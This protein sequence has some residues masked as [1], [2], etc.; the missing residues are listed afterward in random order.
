MN[1][2]RSSSVPG[3]DAPALPQD[4]AEHLLDRRGRGTPR[5][6]P[7]E[8]D[9]PQRLLDLFTA[10]SEALE[11]PFEVV[12]GTPVEQT[13]RSGIAQETDPHAAA[14]AVALL[15]RLAHKGTPHYLRSVTGGRQ[16]EIHRIAMRAWTARHGAVFAVEAVAELFA[17]S[18]VWHRSREHHPT[19][20]RF[21]FSPHSVYSITRHRFHAFTAL[22]ET[23]SLL[24]AM[25]DEDYERARNALAARRTSDAHVLVAAMLMPKQDDWVRD[26]CTVFASHRR[27]THGAN[28]VWA[29]ASTAEHLD[30]IG[31]KA[32]DDEPWLDEPSF[33]RLAHTLGTDALPLLT[34]TLDGDAKPSADNRERIYDLIARL[35]SDDGIAYLTEHTVRPQA[36]AALREAAGRFPVRTL[37]AVAATA[38]TAPPHARARIAG[39]VIE[40]GL[41]HRLPDLDAERR[42]VVEELLASTRRHPVA[43]TLPDAFATPPWAPFGKAA[44]TAVA[45]LAAP[46]VNELRWAPGEREEWRKIVPGSWASYFINDP[47]RWGRMMPNGPDPKHYYFGQYLAW[48]SNEEARAALALW[49][50]G[51]SELENVGTLRAILARFGDEAASRVLELAKKRPSMRSVLLPFVHVEAARVAADLVARPRGDRALGRAW[52]DRHAADAAALLIPDALGKDAK[53]RLS[54]AEALRHLAA[55]HRPVLDEQ[56]AAYGPEAAAAVAAI[57]DADPLDPQRRVSKA[58]AWADPGMLPPLLLRG[59]GAALPADAVRTFIAALALDDPDRL[60]P[61]A[62]LLAAECD[63]VSLTAFSWGLFELWLSVGSPS[64]DGWAMDQLRRFADDR[65]VRGLTALIREWPGQSQNRKAVR[66][67]EILGHIG[68]EAALRSVQSIASNAK[69]KALKKTAAAQIEVI[70]E[71]LELTLDQLADRLVP[72]FG[73][74]SDAPLV[75][76]YGPRAFTVKFDEAL[77]PYVVDAKGK[78]RASAPKPAVSDD[79]DLAQPAYERFALLRKEIKSAATEQVKRLEDAMVQCRSWTVAEF[80]R[81]LVEHPVTWQLTGRLVWEYSTED[82]WR[83]FRLAE[84]RTPAD[85]EDEP[86]DLPEDAQVRIA[87]PLS[88]GKGVEAWAEVFADYEILQ[89]FEQ[90]VR[91][92]FELT[93]EE[94]ESGRVARFEGAK[95]GAGPIIGLLK[96]GWHFG[97]AAQGAYGVF[98]RFP[99]GG[100]LLINSDPGVHPGYGYDDGEQ[101]ITKISVGLPETGEVDP[102]RISEAL[103]TVTRLSRSN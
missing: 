75:L 14:L 60:Y 78:R 67:L 91:P 77:K 102:V 61:G 20:S 22:A 89:P 59:R 25:S 23:R 53:R 57:V 55:A 44:K 51:L 58:P 41:K 32:L 6:V 99:E 84:D 27:Y 29:I 94:R 64:K 101:T 76:D 70:A 54:A 37:R 62:D 39:L 2:N 63:P 43:E 31:I 13:L 80:R 100:Y 33:A 92:V 10:H 8:P 35:P 19:G 98:C 74:S 72:D 7:A 79:P 45:G 21:D 36:L 15:D 9:A 38:P 103:R 88:L 17:N 3:E 4:W 83:S 11:A 56:A 65:T 82:G 47:A 66:G 46:D 28:I 73:L 12:K 69:F 16:E 90:L 5:P 97:E 34:A 85:V 1:L 68:S 30:L 18:L 71:R 81:Y 93:A 24:A 52:L 87:H 49:E 42:A 40:L 95:T 50:G 86:F 48:S 96:R 26:A